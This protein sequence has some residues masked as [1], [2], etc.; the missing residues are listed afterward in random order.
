MKKWTIKDAWTAKH[1]SGKPVSH[2]EIK[3][4]DI[5]E[6][7]R[8][9][10]SSLGLRDRQSMK[11]IHAA[12][13]YAMPLITTHSMPNAASGT[14]ALRHAAKHAIACVKAYC[15]ADGIPKSE[16]QFVV[17]ALKN[18]DFS[19]FTSGDWFLVW[20][21]MGMEGEITD[22]ECYDFYRYAGQCWHY[23]TLASM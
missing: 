14:N 6:I 11:K 3:S 16:Y 7:D 1:G 21:A 20:D 23:A 2:D 5:T 18:L 17:H 22:Q 4:G 9:I 12:L 10:A 13:V 15:K 19:D 8:L